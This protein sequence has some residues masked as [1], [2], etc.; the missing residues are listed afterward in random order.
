MRILHL[1]D[2]HGDLKDLYNAC[3]EDFDVAVF[4]GDMFPN[5]FMGKGKVEHSIKF[6][7][8]AQEL[9]L[10]RNLRGIKRAINSRPLVY[11]SG[12]HDVAVFPNSLTDPTYCLDNGC[13]ATVCGIKFWGF[14]GV[15]EFGRAWN[16]ELNGASLNSRINAIPDGT[17]VVI[18]HTPP[19]GILD[20]AY[21]NYRCGVEGLSDRVIK[22][23]AKVHL[24][25]H[26]HESCGV[27]I[28]SG[29]KFSNAYRGDYRIIEV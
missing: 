27:E 17:E 19:L 9:F 5:S 22:C 25:G 4:T 1:S 26:I 15:Q 6:E 3:T 16:W 14:A 24:F 8:T 2:I 18:T 29:V 12:N 13:G 11:V 21:G 28:N 10:L 20:M 7:K 23:G